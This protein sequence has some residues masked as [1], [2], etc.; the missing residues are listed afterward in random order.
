MEMST[1]MF[2]S[3]QRLWSL[4]SVCL[5][6]ISLCGSVFASHQVRGYSLNEPLKMGNCW[7]NWEAL[8]YPTVIQGLSFSLLL[9]NWLWS[10]EPPFLVLSLKEQNLDKR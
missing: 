4:S 6:S 7:K 3:A 1:G 2:H 8:I 5:S 9:I 10:I